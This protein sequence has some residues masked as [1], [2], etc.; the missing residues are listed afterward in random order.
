MAATFF[1]LPGLSVSN[2]RYA[3]RKLQGCRIAIAC[4]R[5]AQ[6]PHR[7]Y[8][9]VTQVLDWRK[10]DDTFRKCFIDRCAILVED[11]SPKE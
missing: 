10:R 5:P 9:G 8:T 11:A 4:T 2:I 7:T 1:L 3:K 6:D